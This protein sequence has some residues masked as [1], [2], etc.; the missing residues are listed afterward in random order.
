M[1][2]INLRNQP[3]LVEK[4]LVVVVAKSFLLAN[5]NDY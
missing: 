1:A 5:N 4:D 3:Y 2:L